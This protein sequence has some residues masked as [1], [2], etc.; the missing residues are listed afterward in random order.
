MPFSGHGYYCI[1]GDPGHAFAPGAPGKVRSTY[2]RFSR[3]VFPGLRGRRDVARTLPDR[4]GLQWVRVKWRSATSP[5]YQGSREQVVQ[6]VP[7]CLRRQLAGCPGHSCFMK[8]ASVQ[9]A[10]RLLCPQFAQ[11]LFRWRNW[12]PAWPCPVP[13]GFLL[14]RTMG[15][16]MDIGILLFLCRFVPGHH[17]AGGL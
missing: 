3:P 1:I 8:R 5:I 11:Q 15:V 14:C 4:A 7:A 16:L 12:A 17:V 6:L 13:L 10:L 2:A 9:H